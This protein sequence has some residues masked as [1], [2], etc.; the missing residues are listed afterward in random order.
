[1]AWKYK[2]K[3]PDGFEC[4]CRVCGRG[5]QGKSNNYRCPH[6]GIEGRAGDFRNIRINSAE[7]T[8]RKIYEA[9]TRKTESNHER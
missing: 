3:Q 2:K 5:V 1:M 9:L 7:E 6:D 8:R 4:A